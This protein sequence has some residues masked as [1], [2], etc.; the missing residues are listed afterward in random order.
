MKRR[1][2]P[3]G[4]LRLAIL[5]IAIFAVGFIVNMGLVIYALFSLSTEANDTRITDFSLALQRTQAGYTLPQ[6]TLDLLKKNDYWAMLIDENGSVIWNYKMPEDI[7]HHFTLTDVASFSRWYL[8]DYPVKIW[9][10]DSG[11]FVL[12]ESKGSMWK[13]SVEMPMS[14]TGFLPVWLLALMVCNFLVILIVSIWMTNRWNRKANSARDEWIAGVSHDIRTPLSMILGYASDLKE[15]DILPEPQKR[16]AGVIKQK[17]EEMRAL[18]SDLNLVNRLESGEASVNKVWVPLSAVIR[19]IAV[20]FINEDLEEKYPITVEIDPASSD[21]VIPG[22]KKLLG[23]M[24]RNLLYNSMQHNPEGCEI[25]I[26]LTH[27]RKQCNLVITDTGTGFKP[28]Q[29]KNFLEKSQKNN[30]SDHGLGLEIVKRIAFLHHGK[31]QISNLSEGGG[32]CKIVF[33]KF[34][35]LKQK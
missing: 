23:R 33:T 24:L 35:Y 16:E 26:A 19:E 4:A 31:F 11:L 9:N 7:P 12:G 15:S 10:I 29:I 22:D 21:V 8:A 34:A 2:I 17:G 13:Y 27:T 30:S 25:T 20:D 6:E 3:Q 14:Q 32:C 5:L 18:I 28:E 1:N